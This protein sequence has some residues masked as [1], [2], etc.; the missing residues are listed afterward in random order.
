[1]T[2]TLARSDPIRDRYYAWIEYVE[3]ATSISFYLAAVASLLVLFIHRRVHPSIYQLVQLLFVLLVVTVFLTALI[4]RLYLQPRAQD[5]RRSELLSSAFNVSLT[6]TRT[7][8]YYN[9]TETEPMARLAM[10]L[11]ENCFFGKSIVHK[12]LITERAKTT[13]YLAIWAIV[14][15]MRNSPMELV[16][17]AA[18]IVFSEEILLRW[19]RLEWA[20]S[21]Y[22]Q[23]YKELFLILSTE[24][25]RPHFSA[26]VLEAF[27]S[28][29]TGKTLTGIVLPSRIF[30][31]LNK[32]LSSEWLEIRDSLP[33]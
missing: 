14:A 26:L 28:Y 11:F 32:Q 12:M 1:M 16:A 29:E 9:N 18:Q 24:R 31:R 10:C 17:I 6:H 21:R 2:N 30:T 15:L 19:F 8:G 7:V 20:R 3:R 13:V 22:E 4:T 27:G 25:K 23:I 5:A 33:S